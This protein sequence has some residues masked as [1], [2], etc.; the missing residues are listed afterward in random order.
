L[1]GTFVWSDDSEVTCKNWADGQPDNDGE[2]GEHCVEMNLANGLWNDHNCD[3]RRLGF[4]CKL[5]AF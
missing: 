1:Q 5:R 4:I 2:V 3:D